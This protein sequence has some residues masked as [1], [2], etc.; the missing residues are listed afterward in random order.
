M[1]PMLVVILNVVAVWMFARD[2]RRF[3]RAEPIKFWFLEP[4]YPGDLLRPLAV[5]TLFGPYMVFFGIEILLAGTFAFFA[6]ALR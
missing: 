1:W 6:G 4:I 5:V 2:L 3:R